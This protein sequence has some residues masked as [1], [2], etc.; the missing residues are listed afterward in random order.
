MTMKS[1]EI[2]IHFSWRA[3]YLQEPDKPDKIQEGYNRTFAPETKISCWG[4]PK[5]THAAT[6]VGFADHPI[7]LSKTYTAA[8][9]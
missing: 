1:T 7:T 9:R 8:E 3:P 5:L 2:D 6:L 4:L